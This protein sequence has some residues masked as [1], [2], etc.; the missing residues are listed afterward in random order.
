VTWLRID[1]GFA[2]HPK[3]ASLTDRQLRVWIRTLCYCARQKD[4]TVD[5][6]VRAEVPGLTTIV[7]KRLLDLGLLDA[8]GD[9]AEVHDWHKYLPKDGTA[10]ERMAAWRARKTVTVS[11]TEPV[12]GVVTVTAPRAQT[13]AVPVP[14]LETANA[15]SRKPD[16]IWDALEAELGPV[17][18]RSERGK[19]NRVV[20]DLKAVDAKPEE[21][22]SRCRAY[23][24]LWPGVALTDTALSAHW[25]KLLG[26][27]L[28]RA[29]SVC[30]V[31]G[32]FASGQNALADHLYY[33]H[34]QER[35]HEE[36]T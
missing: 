13:R 25:S 11:V 24:K 3:I 4:P 7:V 35:A 16:E 23:R 2:S 15:V 27:P 5:R 34:G 6:V 31:C 9:S 18:T 26:P 8:V 1:D 22:A 20:K 29:G 19:R 10:A 30:P 21:I 32:V 28:I 17:A 12:T 36:A 14:S 33:V